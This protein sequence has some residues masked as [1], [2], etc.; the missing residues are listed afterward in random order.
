MLF[1]HRAELWYND[2]AN[3][4][5]SVRIMTDRKKPEL[6][7]PAG[8]MECVR[9][10][11]RYGADAVYLGGPFMQMRADKVGFTR[12]ALIQA[13][14]EIH[15]A[16][17]KLYVTVN[18][19]AFSDEIPQLGEYA[20][21]LKEIGTDAVIV[22]DIGA[23]AQI[24]EECPDLEIHVSTQANCMNARA[25]RVYYDMGVRRIVLARELSLEQIAQIRA[26]T[27]EDLELE[28]FVHGAMCMSYS[29]R[30]LLSAYLAGR[31]G[32]RGECAQTCRWNYYLMEEKRPGEYF[33]I[34]ED[35]RG[36]AILSSKELCCIEHLKA[37]EEAGI[38]SFKIEGRM[39]T[40]FYTA[41]VVN[42]YRMAIDEAAPMD[43]L[44]KELD[45]VSHRPFCTGFYFGD[46]NQLI[47]DTEGYVRDWLFVATALEASKNGQLRIETRN[48][49]AAG[50]TLE[51]LSPGQT[52][53]AFTV[54]SIANDAGESLERSATPMRVLTIDAPDGVQAGDIL[55]K[56]I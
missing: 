51:Y 43:L 35:E 29:G 56:R 36:S 40:P 24:R 42:A 37:F 47:P 9:A 10:A 27:P 41:T 33:K 4:K 16:G 53:K 12:D 22:S 30:C 7:A 54:S 15:A 32:N 28:A 50:D 38:C 17:R 26:N 11:I 25:A 45:T 49:F 48:P 55:R 23:I 39:R 14:R 2:A 21:F 1:Y 44:R 13:S 3:C 52:G 18:C 5:E 6:L 31:S 19:F 8:D 34:E 20:L 46:P